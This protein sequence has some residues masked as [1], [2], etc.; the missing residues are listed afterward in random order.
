MGILFEHGCLK[1]IFV[2]AAVT[3]EGE[4]H[5]YYFIMAR[6]FVLLVAMLSLV[7]FSTQACPPFTVCTKRRDTIIQ[8][9]RFD[10]DGN[11]V[12]NAGK[13]WFIKMESVGNVLLYFK[14]FNDHGNSV[15]AFAYKDKQLTDARV[16]Y[17]REGGFQVLL[18]DCD[19]LVLYLP[20]FESTL[21]TFELEYYW[22][23]GIMRA[24]A[25]EL[26][27]EGDE[28]TQVTNNTQAMCWFVE[29]DEDISTIYL[30]ADAR[31]GT[32]SSLRVWELNTRSELFRIDPPQE[33]HGLTALEYDQP[34]IVEVS[35]PFDEDCSVQQSSFVIKH[36]AMEKTQMQCLEKSRCANNATECDIDCPGFDKLLR[37]TS[38][39][40]ER[41]T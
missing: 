25:N 39:S 27:Y 36:Q 37:H 32:K 7:E 5:C 10:T 15:A 34:L 13:S 20:A 41:R 24:N 3:R 1:S 33:Q 35:C 23:C 28:H 19:M 11:T 18:K 30:S 9:E 38:A 26:N 8:D 2:A 6:L 14:T 31:L 12:K 40:G 4:K 17:Q 22:G 21:P 29:P 16:F